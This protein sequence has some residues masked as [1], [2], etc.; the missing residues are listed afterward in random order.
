MCVIWDAFTA[1]RWMLSI[2]IAHKKETEF[3]L[4]FFGNLELEI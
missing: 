2:V 3:L 4:V 1:L